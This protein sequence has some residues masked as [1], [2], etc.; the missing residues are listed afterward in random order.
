[1]ILI[2]NFLKLHTFVHILIFSIKFVSCDVELIRPNKL[3]VINY[4]DKNNN[5]QEKTLR[6]SWK[7]NSLSPTIDEIEK[8]TFSLCSG[9]S[10]AIKNFGEMLTINSNMV[11]GKNN[12]YEVDLQLKNNIGTNGYYY[13]QV[14][15]LTD[16]GYSIHYTQKFEMRGMIGLDKAD[17]NIADIR[18]HN[19]VGI[20]GGAPLLQ[21]GIDGK[22][23]NQNNEL[24]GAPPPETA[25][26]ASYLV[27]LPYGKQNGN[28][29][30]APMQT[31]P[32]TKVTAKTWKKKNP[33]SDVSFFKFGRLQGH[34]LTDIGDGKNKNRQKITTEVLLRPNV[35]TTITPM[36]NYKTDMDVNFVSQAKFPSD[37]GGWY[38]PDKKIQRP[39]KVR[40]KKYIIY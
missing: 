4:D 26:A 38:K 16:I 23:I 36:R 32:G 25:L 19:G 6:I 20:G 37:N 21:F 31:Q 10:N 27:G 11:V 1:M 28:I 17:T 3:L 9:P 39:T 30:Y 40:E 2:T 18:M 29:K 34:Y 5:V 24:A 13:I 22:E 35:D 14:F 8:Y 33:I 15:A 7:L 12:I